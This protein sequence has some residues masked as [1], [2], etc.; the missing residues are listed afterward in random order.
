[1]NTKLDLSIIEKV[2][3]INLKKR[4]DR[5]ESI[6]NQLRAVDVSYDKI[7]RFE[8]IESSPGYIGCAKSHQA[9]L[10]LAFNENWENVLIIEDDTAFNLDE[11]SICR[12]NNFLN[13]LKTTVWDVAMLAANYYK[14]DTFNYSNSFLKVN[15]AH[16]ASAYIVNKKYYEILLDNFNASVKKLE[17][18]QPPV[19]CAI[20]AHWFS[21]MRR[22]KWFGIHPCLCFQSAGNSDIQNC[23]C[24]FEHLFHK[25]LETIAEGTYCP[26]SAH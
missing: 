6:L 17:E 5:N 9:A 10:T 13:M 4:S 7:V 20:D 23:Y 19:S 15:M 3:Y 11:E 26:E 12:A 14:V 25:P 2:V 24:N 18:G 8:A 21:L 1:M 22:D 16:C